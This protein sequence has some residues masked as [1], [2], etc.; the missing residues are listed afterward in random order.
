MCSGKKVG[1]RTEIKFLEALS[2]FCCCFAQEDRNIVKVRFLLLAD[3]HL[4]KVFF[5]RYLFGF[6]CLLCVCLGLCEIEDF[7]SI[8]LNRP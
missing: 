3:I 1:A 6:C 5:E 7:R 2:T 4:K 8:V